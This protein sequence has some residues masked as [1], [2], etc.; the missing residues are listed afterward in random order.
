MTW[1][2][3]VAR[4]TATRYKTV[5]PLSGQ[6]RRVNNP[7]LLPSIEKTPDI[8]EAIVRL[9]PESRWDEKVDPDRFSLREAIAHLAEWEEIDRERVRTAA[10]A[11]GATIQG[12]DEGELAIKGR[13][14]ETDPMEKIRFLKAERAKTCRYFETI[15]K[16]R[17]G[18]EAVHTERGAQSVYDLMG[19]ILA[20]DVYHIEHLVRYLP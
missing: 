17:Y 6:N 11:P 19:L 14:H 5:C 18:N 16:S 9:V 7:Y 2:E 15:D 20:H 10:E 8:I 13:Y 12:F 3:Q 4:A 1:H